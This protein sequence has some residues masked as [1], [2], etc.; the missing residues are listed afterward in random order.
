MGLGTRKTSS[1]QPLCFSVKGHSLETGKSHGCF[2]SSWGGGGG[3]GTCVGLV[4]PH[5]DISFHILVFPDRRDFSSGFE[6]SVP[7]LP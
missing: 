5:C 1:E 6:S 2:S 3:G 4:A 7:Q